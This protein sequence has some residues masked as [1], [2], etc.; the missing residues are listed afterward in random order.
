M[1]QIQY[2]E[3]VLL[4]QQLLELNRS[5]AQLIANTEH[6]EKIL[7]DYR[8]AM[9]PAHEIRALQDEVFYQTEAQEVIANAMRHA[10]RRLAELNL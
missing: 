10:V 3:V 4:A 1:T 2:Q 9:K 8:Q 7:A 5:Q 6:L